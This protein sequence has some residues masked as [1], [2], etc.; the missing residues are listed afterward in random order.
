[1]PGI[2]IFILLIPALAALGHDCYLF[3]A[4]YGY[5]GNF[6]LDFLEEK[7]KFSALGYLWTTYDIDSYKMA[8]EMTA[9][10]NWA[11]IDKVLTIK[12]FYAGLGFA[13]FWI[14]VFLLLSFIGKGPFA[15][16]KMSGGG[17][18]SDRADYRRG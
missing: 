10:D 14:V 13:G 3:Y 18:K 2:I 17:G 15:S 1:M 8:V 9:P 7:F 5:Q 12:A 6:S 4:E 16:S 11:I